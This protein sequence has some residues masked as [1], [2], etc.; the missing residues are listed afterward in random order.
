MRCRRESNPIQVIETW[1]PYLAG[2]EKVDTIDRPN[3]G[4]RAGLE[5]LL[6]RI[7]GERRITENR[8][9][10]QRLSVAR[11]ARRVG[12]EY[13]IQLARGRLNDEKRAVKNAAKRKFC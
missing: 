11:I 13:R 3:V 9:F 1:R 7:G 10:D 2:L 12:T 8:R 5:L 6:Y 4:Q